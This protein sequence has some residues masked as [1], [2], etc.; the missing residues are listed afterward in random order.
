MESLVTAVVEPPPSDGVQVRKLLAA[1]VTTP[2][3]QAAWAAAAS[4]LHR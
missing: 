1:C 3:K 4:A 2:S